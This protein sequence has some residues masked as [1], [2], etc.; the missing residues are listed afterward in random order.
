MKSVCFFMAYHDRPS[1]TKMS[2]D[3]MADTARLFN[4]NGITATCLVVGSDPEIESFCRD[5]GL[6]HQWFDNHPL[7]DKF[8]FLWLR[9]IQKRMEYL[10]WMGSNNVHGDGYWIQAM[11]V[12]RGKKV[13][14]FGSRNCVIMSAD[15]ERK[16]T[17]VFRP[18]RGYLISSGQ[19]FLR[20]SLLNSV[21]LLTVYDDDQTFNFDGKILD[22]MTNKW[23]HDIIE[24]VEFDEED[25]IDVKDGT[26]IHSYESYMS[27]DHYPRYELSTEIAPRH[28][29]LKMLFD[30]YYDHP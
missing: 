26:N 15:P 6:D 14:T 19:F 22:S 20:Y 17:C 2:I 27:F 21:N 30:G 29:R 3:H 13:A 12:I 1:L 28:P 5:Q 24:L 23:G 18:S 11:D 4:Q 10:C 8:V 7:S 16:E 25:C 9:A